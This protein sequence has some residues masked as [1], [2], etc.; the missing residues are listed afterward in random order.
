MEEV[1][2]TYVKPGET[3]SEI[4]V[5]YGV[6]MDAL[7]RWNRI[8]N[9]DLVLVGQKVVVYRVVDSPDSSAS[10][11][12]VSHSASHPDVAGDSWDVWIGVAI[13]LVF[14]LFLLRRKRGTPTRVSRARS[15]HQPEGRI[16]SSRDD[17]VRSP[18]PVPERPQEPTANDGERLVRSELRRNYRDWIQLDDVL[19]PT[20][21]GTTQID[22][23]LVSPCGVFVIETKD[24]NGWIFGSPGQ[25]EWTQIYRT[26]RR[27]RRAGIRSERHRLYNPLRQ[28]EG[29]AKALVRLRI[30]DRRWLRPV[31]VFVGD[32]QLRTADK[33]LPFDEHE[34]K[35][36]KNSTWR[37]RGVLCMSLRDLHGYIAFSADTTPGSGLTRR[38]MESISARIRK[39]EIPQS[40][41]SHAEHVE[42]VQSVKE[43]ASR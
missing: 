17:A 34:K 26:N 43:R 5:R 32:A 25:K 15:L 33:F 2:V 28:N 6:D 37:M 11:S 41:K 19:L 39:A 30:V 18:A 16:S 29:H 9:P 38:R 8:D 27:N 35:A 10:E 40:A 22:H 31:V 7:Q 21:R 24:M 13:A 3:L 20:G 36:C 23:I 12:A 42:F 1:I 14:V 4:A